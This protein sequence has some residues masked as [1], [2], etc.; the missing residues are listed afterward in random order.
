MNPEILDLVVAGAS[1]NKWL[2]QQGNGETCC[3]GVDWVDNQLKS[4][5][6]N[7]EEANTLIAELK[8]PTKSRPK[9]KTDIDEGEPGQPKPEMV[10]PLVSLLLQVYLDSKRRKEEEIAATIIDGL[11]YLGILKRHVN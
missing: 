10:A 5:K 11:D 2:G 9:K 6:L 7:E 4:N 1:S 8:R 3:I